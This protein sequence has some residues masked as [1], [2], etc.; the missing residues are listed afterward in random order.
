MGAPGR[1]TS[2][3][4]GQS[5]PAGNSSIEPYLCSHNVLLSHAAAVKV[6]REK[7]YDKEGGQIG[8]TLNVDWAEPASNSEA[9]F[10]ASQRKLIW[11]CAWY[12]DPVW[13]GDY[14]QIMKDYVGDRL[15]KFTDQQKEDLKGSHDFFGL[16][17]YTT[18]WTK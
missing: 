14:P 15:P 4:P 2:T 7:G 10:N 1:C 12:A 3:G 5:C 6:F 11:Q 8:I 16:N 9:D 18:A 13:F 17:H